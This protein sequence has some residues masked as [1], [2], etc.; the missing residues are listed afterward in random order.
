MAFEVERVPV[1]TFDNATLTADCNKEGYRP[2]R[3]FGGFA[4]LINTAPELLHAAHGCTD[5]V[6]APS[7][8]CHCGS[9]TASSQSGH[10]TVDPSKS[11][12]VNIRLPP[13]AYNSDEQC[14][15]YKNRAATS[16][17]AVFAI[18]LI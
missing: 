15:Q 4:T 3:T 17:F 16:F 14:G 18:G 11:S 9:L 13:S 5:R 8:C 1:G 6:S 7:V 2:R 12:Q 10:F